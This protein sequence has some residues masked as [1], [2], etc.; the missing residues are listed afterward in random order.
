[1]KANKLLCPKDD[2]AKMEERE[3]FDSLST[4]M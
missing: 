4:S 2:V 1:M 3:N